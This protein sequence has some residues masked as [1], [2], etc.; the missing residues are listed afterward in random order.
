MD[1]VKNNAS[2]GKLCKYKTRTT[3]KTQETSAQSENGGD[4]EQPP[5]PSVS[6]LNV[7]VIILLNYLCNLLKFLDYL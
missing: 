6:T 3:G 1:D 5:R 2:D 4:S 7:K